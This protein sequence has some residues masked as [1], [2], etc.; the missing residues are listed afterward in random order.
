[1]VLFF[2]S[3]ASV[4]LLHASCSEQGVL[5]RRAPEIVAKIIPVFGWEES[6]GVRFFWL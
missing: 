3:L 4:V 5:S 6:V 2:G 1:M